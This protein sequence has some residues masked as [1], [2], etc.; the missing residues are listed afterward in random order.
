MS[1][2]P[3]LQPAICNLQV[4]K[5]GSTSW[6]ENFLTLADA[7]PEALDQGMKVN[8]SAP[9]IQTS[10]CHLNCRL[11]HAARIS[12]HVLPW[13]IYFRFRA[14][15]FFSDATS[16]QIYEGVSINHTPSGEGFL[17]NSKA[18]YQQGE[19]ARVVVVRGLPRTLGI[20]CS[21]IK[22]IYKSWTIYWNDI[23]HKCIFKDKIFPTCVFNL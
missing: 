18:E 20:N 6:V 14:E 5:A 10:F 3:W 23:F 1:S 16:A 12:L 17:M 8:R 4:P 22:E 7:D 11:Y 2:Q 21:R 13:T 19:V 9:R 15:K